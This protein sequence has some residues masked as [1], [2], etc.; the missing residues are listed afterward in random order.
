MV[1]HYTVF[2]AATFCDVVLLSLNTARGQFDESDPESIPLEAKETIWRIGITQAVFST[3][4]TLTWFV[5]QC[6]MLLVLVKFGR[7]LEQD[8]MQLL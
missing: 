6:M 2:I 1:I 5:Y 3:L 4:Q 7:P 8:A